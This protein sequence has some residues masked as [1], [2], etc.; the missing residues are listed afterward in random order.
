MSCNCNT[1][2]CSKSETTSTGVILIPNETITPANLSGGRLIIACNINTPTANE[3]LYIQTLAGNC[4]VLCRYGNNIL[5]N[6]V[7][8]R[9]PYPIVFGNQNSSYPT[10]QFVITSCACLNGRGTVSSETTAITG[11]DEGATI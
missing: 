2:I 8:K 7:N 3:S 6:Q 9:A 1:I 5:A 10:G 4:P 11:E